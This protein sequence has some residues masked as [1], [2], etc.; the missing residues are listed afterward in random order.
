MFRLLHPLSLPEQEL[1]VQ[2]QVLGLEADHQPPEELH[3]KVLLGPERY[4]DYRADTSISQMYQNQS[5][6]PAYQVGQL[7]CLSSQLRKQ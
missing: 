1:L 2:H 7:C 6:R 3:Q 4:G 5:T